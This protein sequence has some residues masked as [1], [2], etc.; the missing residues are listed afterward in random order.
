MWRRYIER[1]VEFR[2]AGLAAGQEQC[3][4]GEGQSSRIH[5]VW[6]FIVAMCAD[7]AAYFT[8]GM[9]VSGA[10]DHVPAV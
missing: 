3:A 8:A 1:P 7:V 6:F 4:T 5:G 9:K 2:G 10:A